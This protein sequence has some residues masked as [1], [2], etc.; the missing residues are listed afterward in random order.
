MAE[1]SSR[2]KKKLKTWAKIAI[3]AGIVAVLIIAAK[4]L[5]ITI[6]I[7]NALQGA[8]QW[9]DSLGPWGPIAFVFIYI[10]AAV[11]LISGAALTLGAGVLF[12]VVKGSIVVSVAATLGATAAFLVGRYLARDRVAKQIENRPSFKAIDAAVAAEGW[13]IVGLTRLS[14]VFPFVFLNYAFGV[15]QVKLRD[16]FFASWIGMLPGTVMYVYIGSLAKDL[17]TLGAATEGDQTSVLRWAINIIGFV[18]TVAVT[19]YVT[20]VAR[21]ALA[22]KVEIE[23]SKSATIADES[24]AD[25]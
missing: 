12:G 17:A 18:A 5:G 10:A 24:S 15:T 2:P 19:L 23:P 11:F 9:I 8:L 25:A 13:K 22:N 21:K 3:A 1:A 14:P 20:K 4:Q 16:Y 6:V 7:N